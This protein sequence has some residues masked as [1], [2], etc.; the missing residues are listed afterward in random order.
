M[1]CEFVTDGVIKK[2]DREEDFVSTVFRREKKSFG[3]HI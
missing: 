2:R 3:Q 1:L